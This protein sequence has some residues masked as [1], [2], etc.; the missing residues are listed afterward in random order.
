MNIPT[1]KD[2]ILDSLDLW[3]EERIDDMIKDNTSL[4]IPSVYLKRGCHNII[5]KYEGKI[6]EGIDN[7]ALFLTD[8]NGN[9][10]AKTVFEDIMK[11]FSS[12]EETSFDLGIIKGI[13]GKGKLSLTLPDNIL[14]NIVFGSNKA[15]TFNEDDFLELKD[16]LLEKQ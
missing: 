6:S 11:I 4:A 13:V 1:L 9:I 12:M 5:N 16:L 10:D 3:L 14:T 8:E 15:I 2:K 7:A